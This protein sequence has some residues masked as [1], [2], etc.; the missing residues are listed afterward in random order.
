MGETIDFVTLPFRKTYELLKKDYRELGIEF[1]KLYAL[2]FLVVIV[3]ILIAG[4]LVLLT[5]FFANSYLMGI[6]NIVV[7]VFGVA[8]F[9][10][11]LVITS[12]LTGVFYN[13]VHEKLAGKKIRIIEKTRELTAP[14]G[15]YAIVM[16]LVYGVPLLG[17]PLAIVVFG[18]SFTSSMAGVIFLAVALVVIAPIYFILAFFLQFAVLEIVLNRRGV[19]DSLKQSYALVRKN[20][21][22]TF[23]FDVVFV[24]VIFAIAAAFRVISSILGFFAALSIIFFPLLI[25]LILAMVVLI[26]IQSVVTSLITIPA[27]YYF[28]KSIGGMGAKRV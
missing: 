19:I 15:R 28:W 1:T 5:A 16:L 3:A 8:I 9:L 22:V 12:A 26:L 17:M 25:L 21:L 4:A 6:I 7:L 13:V 24:L 23:G 20:L 2:T 18:S 11:T 27:Q 14:M 10:I